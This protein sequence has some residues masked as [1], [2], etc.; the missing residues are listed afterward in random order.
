MSI[1]PGR[2]TVVT[3]DRPYFCAKEDAHFQEL[4]GLK[5]QPDGAA[6][7][8]GVEYY[9][10]VGW[11]ISTYQRIQSYRHERST[12]DATTLTPANSNVTV[13]GILSEVQM[14][15]WNS[16]LT[17]VPQGLQRTSGDTHLQKSVTA[18]ASWNQSLTT[19]ATGF[20]QPGADDSVPMDRVLVALET[21]K[22]DQQI[23]FVLWPMPAV[24]LN[25]V[26]RIV[27]IYFTSIPGKK[28]NELAGDGS[29]S[30]TL[31]GDG[32][33]ELDERLSNGSW[34]FRRKMRWCPQSAVAG[35]SHSVTISS[36][37]TQDS[38]K[39]WTGTKL[40][41][42][43]GSASTVID[44]AVD[45]L[46]SSLYGPH[47]QVYDIPKSGVMPAP[48][49]QP[50]RIDVRRDLKSV[51]QV[52]LSKYFASAQIITVGFSLPNYVID[53]SK[54]VA[55]QIIGSIPT[56]T[57]VDIEL[58]GKDG[59]VRTSAGVTA[60]SIA[61][62]EET[63]TP[64]AG[65]RFYYA[66]L[67]LHANTDGS[68]SPTFNV[69]RFIRDVVRGSHTPAT[70]I[71][72]TVT[73]IAHTGQDSDPS[74]ETA[75]IQCE[76]RTDALSELRTRGGQPVA[77]DVYYDNEDPTLYSRIFSGYILRAKGHRKGYKK[78]GRGSTTQYPAV[79][80]TSYDLRCAGEW[81][82]LSRAKAPRRIDLTQDAAL[83]ESAVVG[84]YLASYI[85]ITLLRFAGVPDEM[86]DVPTS[87]V[88]YF[89]DGALPTVIEP[90]T[91]LAP[92][93]IY[94]VRDYM[95]GYLVF[96]ANA[97]DN[98]M[99]RVKIPPRPNNSGVY[100]NLASFVT[101]PNWTSGGFDSAFYKSYGST[102][103]P[104]D[105]VIQA[106]PMWK[107]TYDEEMIPPECNIIYCS[108]VIIEAFQNGAIGAGISF[109]RGM[110]VAYNWVSANFGQDGTDH[111]LPDANSPDYVGY[112]ISRFVGGT[113]L[114]GEQAINFT[115]RRT[116]D[117]CCHAKK[118]ASFVAPLALVTDV[119]DTKQTRPRP[120]MFGDPVLVDG[121]QFYIWSANIDY[122]GARG[123]DQFQ[124]C[125]YEAFRVPAA[126]LDY[127]S[128]LG[129]TD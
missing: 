65:D 52:Q 100:A 108:G 71:P 23:S 80:W 107:D 81:L 89:F 70:T 68:K 109:N 26:Q 83:V 117:L 105:Q 33:A 57:S 9:P 121:E 78:G 32:H 64:I 2:K 127:K 39:K 19:D 75:R 122:S 44:T 45:F 14:Q 25:S 22:P 114:V 98:G 28:A 55:V 4:I 90:F 86:I 59:S 123:G 94:M 88:R 116:Y 103:G 115:L 43:F 62:K 18:G 31:W 125:A 5:I 46:K 93:L 113:D 42:E 50:I 10:S 85:V 27:R 29:Y 1:T 77:I 79:K 24:G 119:L 47:W 96:D 128:V 67:T 54:P 99:W 72:L 69:L 87:S 76:D 3:F 51:F 48:T 58:F 97:G 8:G 82:Q 95:G 104:H 53:V 74:H 35:N 37:A 20:S 30:L 49:L 129:R 38:D 120:L 84:G 124:Q 15:R 92:F 73:A 60:D 34:V 111:P 13:A 66:R 41:F 112:P 56:G 36:D 11:R 101:G 6:S 63:F 12:T 91:E 102:T 106:Y 40:L 126:T 16:D 61:G 110:Q 7:V 118:K 21:H 17:G